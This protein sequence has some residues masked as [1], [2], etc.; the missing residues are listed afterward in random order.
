MRPRGRH[1]TT[2]GIRLHFIEI[3]GNGPPL[4]LL[5]GITSPAITWQFVGNRLAEFAHV[6]I[7][8]NRGRGLSSRGSELGYTLDDYA[9]DAAGFINQLGLSDAIVLGHSMGARIAFALAAA[10]PD[11]LDR[12]IIVDPPM[13]GPG[14]DPYPIPL[15]WYLDGID[16]ACRGEETDKTSPLLRNWTDAQIALRDE[17]LPTCDKAAVAETHRLFH[18]EDIY[19]LF[20]SVKCSSLLIYAENGNTVT[21]QDAI[22]GVG[23]MIPWDDL[24]A[25]IA[26]VH[27]FIA[28]NKLGA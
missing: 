8:D 15:K 5:P 28:P 23:H 19:A 16:A 18:E 13:S 20:S 11:N 12:I 22:D 6:Y 4:V 25:F 24:D 10:F 7:L 14:R 9:A 27:G 1:V 3:A 21:D 26:S 17:W 2:N